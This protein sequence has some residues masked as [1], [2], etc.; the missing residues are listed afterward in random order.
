MTWHCLWSTFWFLWFSVVINII[1]PKT[2]QGHMWAPGVIPIL[3][4]FTQRNQMIKAP[5]KWYTFEPFIFQGLDDSFCDSNWSMFAYGSKTWLYVPAIQQF[6]KDVSCENKVDT[7]TSDTASQEPPDAVGTNCLP[8]P[9]PR[10]SVWL[11]N[12]LYQMELNSCAYCLTFS[13]KPYLQQMHPNSVLLEKDIQ[14]TTRAKG[15]QVA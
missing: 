14:M 10:S 4:L 8:L 13:N 15:R 11:Q 2:I 9:E 1:G 6:Y 5:N 12:D 7:S 3:E